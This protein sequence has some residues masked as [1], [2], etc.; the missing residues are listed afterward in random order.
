[1][2]TQSH[3][4]ASPESNAVRIPSPVDRATGSSRMLRAAEEDQT[5]PIGLLD[6][7]NEVLDLVVIHTTPQVLRRL[8]QVNVQFQA[9]VRSHRVCRGSPSVKLPDNVVLK[10]AEYLPSTDVLNLSLS[11]HY[12]YKLIMCHWLR[13]KARK[14][15]T[16]LIFEY[17]RRNSKRI[18]Q[19]ILDEGADA[20]VIVMVQKPRAHT[21]RSKIPS[22]L[23]SILPFS[24]RPP[25]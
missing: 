12:N 24:I 19:T 6:L 22:A 8:E 20:N 15:G 25:R 21:T 7:P 4:Y 9:L 17:V 16:F 14:L 18:V 13:K 5:E 3:G 2:A 10:I 1:M 11:N 23:K